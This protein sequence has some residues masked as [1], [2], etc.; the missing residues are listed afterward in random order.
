MSSDAATSDFLRVD[1][2]HSG[3]ALLRINRPE[4]R[5]A[6]NADLRSAV[7]GA[8]ALA[9][10]EEA[11]RCVVITGSDKVF[12]AGADIKAMASAS[13]ETLADSNTLAFWTALR[14]FA[15]PLI[16]A[17]NGAALGGGC[18]LAMCAD[19]IIA[20]ESAKFG[21]P[22]I[23]LGII[24]GAGG[25]QLLPRAIGKFKAMKMLLA[26]EP[27]SA[28][29]AE[30]LG[31]VSEVTPDAETLPRALALANI[32]AAMAPLAAR[33]IKDLVRRGSDLPLESAL[34]AERQA[35]L[36]MFDTQDQKEGMR[37]FLEK[38]PAHFLGR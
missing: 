33:A 1:R 6:L 24:P 12:V 5:N 14:S 21:Q 3:V 2:P 8:L 22:E 26:G 10:G 4:A 27:V 9:A 30:I 37:A 18:E 7:V 11:V 35:F 31:L 32:I 23:R 28:R 20:G 38:R 16:A 29:E 13:H 15:K 36:T 34:A 25:T 17:V 19:I